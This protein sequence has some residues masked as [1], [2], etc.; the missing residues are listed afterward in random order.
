MQ[1]SADRRRLSARTAVAVLL[2]VVGML[3]IGGA[4]SSATA[5]PPD[6]GSVG[7]ADDKEPGGQSEGDSPNAGYECDDQS[8]VGDGNPAH[9]GCGGS[10]DDDGPSGS[11]SSSEPEPTVTT[12]TE[13]PEV[14]QHEPAPAEVPRGEVLAETEVRAPEAPAPAAAAPAEL[15]LTGAM[16]QALGLLG[17]A[18]LAFGAAFVLVAPRPK[19]RLLY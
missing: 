9:T 17:V 10:T 4:W 12:T 11:G 18:L 1:Q 2:A 3:A 8:G 16:T 19:Q 5:A 6:N 7:N 14:E 13:A 15:A